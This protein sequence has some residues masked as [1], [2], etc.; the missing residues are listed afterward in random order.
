[1]KIVMIGA[2]Y[3][4]LVSGACFADFGHDVICVDKMPEKIEALKS[5]HIPIFEPGLEVIVAN[6]AKAGRL[7][8]TTDL[9]SAVANADVVF[10]A[11]GTPSRRGDGHADLGY[12][13]SA[14]KEIAHSLEGFTVIV[15]K[16][17]VPVGTGDEV[18]RIIREE[19]PSADFAVVS[20]PEFLREGAAIED[21]KRP[22]RIVVGLSDER[23]RPVMTEV[24]RPL[25]LN[26]SPLLFTTR[27]TSELI[28]YA[29]N[30]F[31]AMKITFI[32]EMADLCEKVGANVQD[33]SR[34][35]GLD[36]RIGAKFLHAG[37]GYG[38]S[39]FPKDTLAL[40]KTAQDYDAPVRLIETTIAIND[41][42]KRAM[43]RKVI[44][45]VGGDVRGKKIAVLGLTFKPNTDDMRDSPAIAIIQ[46]LQDGGARVVGYDPEGMANARLLMEDIDYATGPYEA[47]Q[48]ADAVVIVTEWNQF[49]ALD[50][51]RLKA[52]MKS[53]VLVDLRNI[54]RTD[55]I[56]EHGFQYRSV[57]RPS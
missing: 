57:G 36:G 1:M 47:A 14:A 28:K 22:D 9:S 26:Q 23:A 3:V 34:G 24:Y 12:V 25:Y 33:I 4:G 49:R 31:L 41:N 2:G 21:F 45:A 27:R 15:T 44:N 55:E 20:N 39:C 43:G 16:S 35:I 18:E 7:S 52:I 5:G 56:E 37:P 51:P 11:V 10:I 48:D 6:N 8:F 13:Y 30:A 42:R 32:N 29:A 54:Y 40:A 46:T 50:L 17:T 53:P 38:G 19:N